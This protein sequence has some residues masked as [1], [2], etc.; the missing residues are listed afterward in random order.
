MAESLNELM[1]AVAREGDRGAY[2]QLFDHFAPRVKAYLM[3]LG[4]DGAQAEE[5]LQDIMLQVWRK[6]ETFDPRQAGVSTW[7]FRIARNRRIDLLRRENRPEIDPDDPAL[8]GEPQPSADTALA[9]VQ[10]ADRV[11]AAL[12]ALPQ[13][14]ADLVRLAFFEDYPHSQ[15]AALREL[16][17][18]T[19]KSRIR[20]ALSRLRQALSGEGVG[21]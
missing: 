8:V 10:D 19:V 18:G 21:P 20:L 14:Q 3:R 16:P 1:L 4:A 7:V 12:A 13:E 2:A 17:L 9:Q 6:A 5:L 11:Q 15:I